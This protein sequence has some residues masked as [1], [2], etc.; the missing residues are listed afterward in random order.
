MSGAK[1]L[2]VIAASE[3]LVEAAFK[4]AKFVKAVV[5]QIQDAPDQI[6]RGVGRIE[7][8]A[9]LAAQIKTTKPLQTEDVKN[10][11][12][13]CESYMR[14][15]QTLLEKIS[16]K[17]NDALR[18]KTWKAICGLQEEEDI[19]KLFAVLHQE[20]S[21]LDT[22]IN[23]R[24]NAVA[25]AVL[26]KL[27]NLDTQGQPA[28]PS[29]KCLQDLFITDSAIDRA[30]LITSKGE[31]VSGT[32]DWIAQRKEFV[33]WIASG[34]GLLW[35]S[36]G[37]GLGK[38]M[39][40][41]YLTEYLSSYFRPLGDGKRHF[42]TFFFCDAKDNT[43]NNSVAIVR[44]LLFQ[45]LQQRGDLIKHI[46]PTYEVQEEKTF[47][48][49]SFET[50]WSILIRMINDVGD[51]QVS[52]VLDG[53]DECEPA[54]LQDLLNKL[55][56]IP[57]SSPKL[58]I[59][60]LSREHPSCLEFSLGQFLR[61]R[62]DPDA[63]AEVSNG[64]DL[65]ISARVAEISKSKKYPDQLTNN[66]TRILRHKSAGTYLWISFVVQ[67]L[68]NVE[69]S[70][71]EE[72]LDQLPR[73]L[74]PLYER[75]LN[76]V[77][78]DYRGLTLDILRWCTFAVEPLTLSQLASILKIKPTDLLDQES[79]LRGKLTYCGH[80]LSITNDVIS[81]V[82]QSAYDFLTRKIP[83]H[84]EIPWFSLS[85]A[86]VEQS[87]LASACIAYFH[88]AYLE[89]VAI[90][91]NMD[92]KDT[93]FRYP[94]FLYAT[95]QWHNHFNHSSQH[96]I[97]ILE[98]YSQ[99]FFNSPV[100]IKWAHRVL[101]GSDVMSVA[102]RLGLTVLMQRIL[103]DKGHRLYWKYLFAR[104]DREEDL[105]I[106]SANGHLSIVKLLLKHGVNVDAGGG[107][108]PLAY[109]SYFGHRE[110]VECLLASGANINGAEGEV[111]P[112]LNAIS[113]RNS[114]MVRLLLEWKPHH[115]T[116]PRR[117][118][119]LLGKTTTR[120][121]SL[122]VN[123]QDFPEDTPLHLAVEEGSIEIIRLLLQH[124]DIDAKLVNKWGLSPMQS[125]LIYRQADVVQCLVKSGK[126]PLPQP[127][128]NW[129]CGAIHFATYH[130]TEFNSLHTTF[131]DI[132]YEPLAD[133]IEILQLITE[134]LGVDPQFRTA[135]VSRPD[136]RWHLHHTVDDGDDDELSNSLSLLNRRFSYRGI[137]RMTF[138]DQHGSCY[139][140]ALSLCVQRDN[141]TAISYFLG[142]C[143]VDPSASCR[144][145]DG[146]TALHVAA[147]NLRVDIVR[148]LLS[149]WK[150][151]VNCMD[152]FERTPLH[153]VVSTM[154]SPRRDITR[155][156]DIITEL[157]A[158]GAQRT[159][160]DIHGHTP[161]DLFEARE[162]AD[163][164]REEVFKSM[165]LEKL[166]RDE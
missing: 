117:N 126:V 53:L 157:V 23:L 54:S 67:D 21:T 131:A 116:R 101:Y 97:R 50:I 1:V 78:Q 52:C 151:D 90:F 9:S 149:K 35:I 32:C 13:R 68:H 30:K 128:E 16:F 87:R 86:E 59:I 163:Q 158:A 108:T 38:T 85:S 6:R 56:N 42:S 82:H 26:A 37:P 41:I 94:F 83:N 127:D 18:K 130:Y 156:K 112:L 24:T 98:E 115:S 142:S 63:R 8:L 138:M 134:E 71:V 165:E 95:H 44:G 76:Q 122:D 140:T 34:G 119:P 72:S 106:A 124:P 20:Y 96:G 11:L 69:V 57:S 4:L 155:G 25:E 5:D 110:I 118:W 132:L 141:E 79:V 105:R 93:K 129:G 123:C 7:S 64:L 153:L 74:Y 22:H 91:E 19:M 3:Q 55:K 36:G 40:S 143:N 46:L 102:A 166:L 66:V 45:L 114:Q 147:Q 14:E 65:Y 47:Q 2:G 107:D 27:T 58:K 146:A 135:K 49:N 84:G 31:I 99:F 39:L 133:Q 100:W 113:T 148:L 164:E 75:I 111:P 136:D 81:L 43:R 62:L 160:M 92:E 88:D 10:I 33:N 89:D 70:E 152:R 121:H 144:G 161:R 103:E 154:L 104:G 145:C 137:G 162:V 80:F 159:A 150:V 77:G 61:I 17:H 15:L 48:Q 51:S 29:K 73:G 12:I 120:E 139:E 60:V 28:N 109:A 125:A